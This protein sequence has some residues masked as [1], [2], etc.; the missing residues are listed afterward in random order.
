MKKIADEMFEAALKNVR[1]KK[2]DQVVP[3]SH[4]KCAC[5]DHKQEREW[6]FEELK[7]MKSEVQRACRES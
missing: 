6:M 2:G 5:A 4:P 1:K 7:M 3:Q